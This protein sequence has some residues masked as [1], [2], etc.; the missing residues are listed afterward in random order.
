MKKKIN[1]S[2]LNNLLGRF[3]LNIIKPVTKVVSSTHLDSLLSTRIVKSIQEINNNKFLV[4]YIPII[5]KEVC[6][7]HNIDYLKV[8]TDNNIK[9]NIENN[10]DIF[11][12]VSVII[13]AL[14]TSYA[15][16][17]MLKIFDKILEFGGNVYYS[18]TDSIVTDIPLEKILPNMVGNGIGQFKQEYFVKEAYFISNKTYC[19]VLENDII[20]KCKGVTNDSLTLEN[21]K[22]MYLNSENVFA[23]KKSSVTDLS[24]GSVII[25]E[26]KIKIQYN[27]Y[28]KRTKIYNKFGKWVDT[29][30]LY[31]NNI[32]KD[33]VSPNP[34]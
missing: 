10:I 13:A 32:I 18:D 23:N 21:F 20:I 11:E 30:P 12:D 24:K 25:T 31:Y 2:L 27:T 6:L 7:D 9:F 8:L 26:R 29:K 33:I 19:L 4:N 14:I 22:Q 34:Q 28:L 3:G 17:Y 5:D 15:R 16:V 1:K